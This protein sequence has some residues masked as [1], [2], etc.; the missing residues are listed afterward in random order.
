M[1]AQQ[2]ALDATI[3]RLL[4]EIRKRKISF[5][6]VLTAD[7]GGVDVT[8]RNRDR[9]VNAQ[10]MD[11]ALL[12]QNMNQALARE[13]NLQDRLLLGSDEF[14]SDVYVPAELP[15]ERR[16]LVLNAA[17]RRY[18]NHP[19]VAAVFTKNELIGAERP[20][21]MVDEWTLLERAK[22]SFDPQRSGDLIVLLKPYVNVYHPP[23]NPET[24]YVT[25]HGSPWNYDRRVPIMFWWSGV[26][27]FEQP[28]PVQTVDIAPTL[29]TLIGLKIPADEIDGKAL[30][31]MA[32]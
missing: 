6:V 32:R 20:T 23:R 17:R 30:E 26:Q 16:A 10:R 28:T 22:A 27:G 15:A 24:D 19:Q 5:A 3:G 31:L 25:T 29:A 1:C 2:V 18:L 9:G 12:P 21:G 14:T 13:L 7:H 4:A 8:E 11:T